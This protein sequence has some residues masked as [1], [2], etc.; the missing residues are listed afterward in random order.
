M[1]HIQCLAL[2]IHHSEDGAVIFIL[3]QDG[4][5]AS[6]AGGNGVGFGLQCGSD[7]SNAVVPALVQL[8]PL[9]AT[10]YI[11]V[12]GRVAVAADE[13]QMLVVH[14]T[15]FVFITDDGD[16][17]AAGVAVCVLQVRIAAAFGLAI[18]NGD[19]HGTTLGQLLQQDFLAGVLHVAIITKQTHGRGAEGPVTEGIAAGSIV[20]YGV[21]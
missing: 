13:V 14:D 16:Q 17:V 3:L 19:T 12:A 10:V 20:F 15:I 5:D 4:I 18:L 1:G 21:G 2:C 6:H 8:S 11:A 7:V 9:I